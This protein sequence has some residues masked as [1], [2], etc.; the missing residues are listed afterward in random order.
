MSKTII[1]RKSCPLCHKKR[2]HYQF[3]HED[4]RV[5]QCVE[6][7]MIF[8][9]KAHITHTPA[10]IDIH[11]LHNEVDFIGTLKEAA[12]KSEATGKHISISI[13]LIENTTK[14][15]VSEMANYFTLRTLKTALWQSGL[16]IEHQELR[17]D[18][19]TQFKVKRCSYKPN[20][21]SIILPAYNE[22]G[23]IEGTISGILSKQHL[24]D[25]ELI[26]VESASTD[27]TAEI[28]NKFNNYP[29]VRV[30]TQEKA[31]G[32]G[33]AV[34]TGL[35]AAKGG[36]ILIQDADNEY[37]INDYDAL[38]EPILSLREEF[39]LGARHGGKNLL[40]LRNFNSEKNLS[41]L[42]NFGH[43]LFAGLINV[44]FGQQLRDPFTMYKVFR[45]DT[46]N[47]LEFK[48]NRFDF[49]IELL[50]KII[51]NGYTPVEIPVNY[52]SRGFKEGKKVRIFAD[53]ITWLRA[54]IRLKLANR[55]KP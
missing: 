54:I 17:P 8:G 52:T 31:S 11:T 46:I 16:E 5:V 6:C 34:R 44:L 32:K 24:T 25:Y 38:I 43:L 13:P 42:L 51:Q 20:K 12:K 49:D 19:Y 26:V 9:T 21:L 23:T 18:G 48:C 22:A 30:I 37:D 50:I 55:K 29:N 10:S 35:K 7:F 41:H 40:K 36:I 1:I 45:R 15:K 28:V 47:G 39:V 3:S 27:G 14:S 4:N 2:L 33:N 53:P